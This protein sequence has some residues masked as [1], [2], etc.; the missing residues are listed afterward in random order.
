MDAPS[1]EPLPTKPHQPGGQTSRQFWI[2]VTGAAILAVGIGIAYLSFVG[3]CATGTT[4]AE[5]MAILQ[6][7]ADADKLTLYSFDGSD[8]LFASQKPSAEGEFYGCPVLGKVEIADQ[9]RRKA[10]VD[11]VGVGIRGGRFVASCFWP[12]H[13]IRAEKDGQSVDYIICFYCSNFRI[14][15]GKSVT[16]GGATTNVSEKLLNRYLTE[17]GVPIAN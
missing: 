6:P 2:V 12:H 4:D 16:G 13:A 1:P 9:R 7:L 15:S 11:A 3:K 5:I 10:I 14:Y 8:F 17:A